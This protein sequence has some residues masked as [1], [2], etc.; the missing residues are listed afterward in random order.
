LDKKPEFAATLVAAFKNY[1]QEIWELKNSTSF[2]V[3]SCPGAR[4]LQS[5]KAKPS[6]PSYDFKGLLVAGAR[7]EL[8]T[9]RL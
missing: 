1:P 8:T 7:F 2:P 4:L 5:P 9:F 3:L 6:K